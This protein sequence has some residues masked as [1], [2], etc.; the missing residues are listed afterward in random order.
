MAIGRPFYVV[1]EFGEYVPRL[2][3]LDNGQLAVANYCKYG[4]YTINNAF[5]L[6]GV[7]CVHDRLESGVK[8]D[9]ISHLKAKMDRYEELLLRKQSHILIRTTV[10]IGTD[11]FVHKYVS[12][13][14]VRELLR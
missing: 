2:V 13:E 14:E 8:F 10:D 7:G 11:N 5:K 12:E 6:V 9:N 1:K 4:E 3:L